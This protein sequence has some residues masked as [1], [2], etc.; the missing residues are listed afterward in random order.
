[1]PDFY[2]ATIPFESLKNEN[3]QFLSQLFT[4]TY[5]P[6]LSV[7]NAL[8]EQRSF[9]YKKIA[10]AIGN[11][12]S[13][14][15]IKDVEKKSTKYIK[16]DH[17]NNEVSLKEYYRSSSFSFSPLPFSIEEIKGIKR[18]FK[19]VDLLSGDKASEKQIKL[20]SKNR[21]LFD[22]KIIHFATHAKIIE[23]FPERSSIILSV[24]GRKDEEDGLL[25]YKEIKNLNI[26]AEF[27]NLSACETGLGKISATEGTI[28]LA[29]SF[30]E[31]GAR[32]IS[33]SLWNINDQTTSVFM[34][35]MY[36]KVNSGISYKKA[37]NLT[38]RE[39]INGRYGISKKHPSFWAPYVYYGE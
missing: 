15:S 12:N 2:L 35:E 8:K 17:L 33:V 28:G 20:L 19:N 4:I 6:S 25:T 37:I 27:V 9:K 3:E 13:I 23:D 26:K 5:I 34:N 29:R 30:F 21:K 7:L 22:Y 39:F 31:A 1:M 16:K 36:K 10:L 14:E 18:I 32:S 24:G 11:V 38:K